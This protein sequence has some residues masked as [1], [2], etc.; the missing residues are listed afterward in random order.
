MNIERSIG[1]G[2]RR[3]ADQACTVISNFVVEIA[4]GR[5]YPDLAGIRAGFQKISPTLGVMLTTRTLGEPAISVQMPELEVQVSVSYSPDAEDDLTVPSLTLL[6]KLAESD[7]I[8]VVLHS[9]G[10]VHQSLQERLY[11][12]SSKH[13]R[14][15]LAASTP[16]LPAPAPSPDAGSAA[17][18]DPIP[19]PAG[20]PYPGLGRP[21]VGDRDDYPA[22]V[23]RAEPSAGSLRNDAADDPVIALND[24]EELD[25]QG[26]LGQPAIDLRRRAA[27]GPADSDLGAS[28]FHVQR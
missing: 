14:F 5:E 11:E 26:F 9:T 25:G 16:P 4:E 20:D 10:M 7:P 13:I 12:A 19:D 2:P 8:E 22:A 24:P 18:L 17:R 21:P 23:S 6:D 27:P 1:A 3:S 28:P 15:A